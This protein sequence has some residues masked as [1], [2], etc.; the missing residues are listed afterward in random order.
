MKHTP[1]PRIL[2]AS[3]L[4]CSLLVSAG[5]SGPTEDVRVTLCKNL[6]T[7][8]TADP[9]SI[10]WKDNKNTFNRPAYAVTALTFETLDG[11][12]KRTTLQ[13]ACHYAYEALEDTAITLA[14]PLSAYANL[15]FK[16]I[17]DGRQLSDAEL[18]QRINAEQ[19]RLGRKAVA[20]LQQGA[21]DVADKVRSG[22]GQ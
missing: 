14:D 18:L 3:G 1:M 11:S 13:A 2:V 5:C 7:A 6:S 17:Y 10:E 8:L 15:P 4:F 21:R 12:G 19:K 16:M 9:D 22:V 20:T